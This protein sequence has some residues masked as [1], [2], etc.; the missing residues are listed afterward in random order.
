MYPQTQQIKVIT[1]QNSP[2]IGENLNFAAKI[3]AYYDQKG[4]TYSK[5]K[6]HYNIFYVEGMNLDFTLNK[7]RMDEWN[8]LRGVFAF[9]PDG[10]AY[11]VFL[12]VC[13]TEPGYQATMSKEAKK[14]FGVA[15]IKF[16]QYTAWR[17]GFHKKARSLTPHPALVQF[18]QIPVHRDFNRDG[19]RTGDA[20]SQ[21]YGINQHGTTPGYIGGKISNW[22]AG[23]LVGQWWPQHIQFINLLK[24][25]ARYISNKR[26]VYTTAI[27]AGD[28]YEKSTKAQ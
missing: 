5:E 23:C 19:L 6:D 14:V 3:V 11:I 16:G 26:F 17:Q 13:T 7:D 1:N 15:R 25:D 9:N 21:G 22:S 20:V 27:I 2:K 12:A 10:V 28:D 24:M 4:Y 18:G 8:D